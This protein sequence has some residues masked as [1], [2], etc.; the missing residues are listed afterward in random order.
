MEITEEFKNIFTQS[1]FDTYN[2]KCIS[3]E[4]NRVEKIENIY[5]ISYKFDG[6]L[7]NIP[8]EG[9]LNFFLQNNGHCEFNVSGWFKDKREDFVESITKN[10][11]YL[12]SIQEVTSWLTYNFSRKIDIQ[13]GYCWIGTGNFCYTKGL[14]NNIIMSMTPSCTGKISLVSSSVNKF[15]NVNLLNYSF[16]ENGEQ[17]NFEYKTLSDDVS[18]SLVDVADNHVDLDQ[19]KKRL[20]REYMLTYS[21]LTSIPN[22]LSVDEFDSLSYQH[23]IDYLIVQKMQDIF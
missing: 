11:S 16:F 12:K 5:F 19:F 10:N 1:L 22:L 14:I 13:I 15:R 3:I 17:S 23:I 2:I 20:V 6:L 7:D 4:K 18:C 21:D 8:F 9:A